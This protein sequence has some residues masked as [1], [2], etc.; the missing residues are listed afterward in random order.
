MEAWLGPAA[1][2]EAWLGPAALALA[3][4]LLPLLYERCGSFRFFCKMGF[5]NGWILLLAL[6]AIP[7]CALRGRD[8]ENM[9]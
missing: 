5:Y 7:L 8:V 9:K 2:M 4:L 6:I 3:L 1:A